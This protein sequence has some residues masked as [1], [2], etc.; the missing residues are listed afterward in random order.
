MFECFFGP[1]LFMTPFGLTAD[2]N[3]A[4]LYQTLMAKGRYYSMQEKLEDQVKWL[5]KN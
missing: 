5:M 1:Q 2:R 4:V 3:A